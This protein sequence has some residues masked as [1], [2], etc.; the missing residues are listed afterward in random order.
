VTRSV[1]RPGLTT[2]QVAQR[3]AAGQANQVTLRTARSAWSIVRANVL[4]RFNA[5]IG[6]LL[7]VVLIFGA[8]Q[9]GLFGL[10]ILVN[11][12]VGIIQELRAKRT[13]DGLALLEQA[14]VRVRR[15]GAESEVAPE[16]VVIDDVILLATGAK[17]PVDGD[18]LTTE[19]LEVDESLLT[20]E[21]D[22]VA[23]QPGDPLLSGSFVVAGAGAFVATKVGQDAYA[24]RL[25]HDA[26]RFELAHS[27]LMAG[28][29]HI[30]R[31]I[32]WVIMPV[33]L[34][35]VVSQL[36][37]TQSLSEAMVS[38]VAGIVP[39]VPEG[40]VLLTSVAFAVGVIRLGRRNCL[41]QE[42]A[43]V[44]V[45]A[46]VDVLCLD[47]TG[48]LT[49]P[50]LDL[51]EIRLADQS[52]GEQARQALAA[53]AGLDPAPNATMRAIAASA[54]PA[55]DPATGWS[56]TATISFSSAR[57]YSA[58]QFGER[59]GWVL[60]AADIILA[61][62]DPQRAQAESLGATGL[63][64]LALGQLAD[65]RL[66]PDHPLGAVRPVALVVLRQ[67]LRPEAAE[68]LRFLTDEGLTVKIMSGDNA[69]SVGA[70][71]DTLHV[72]GAATPIDARVL[73]DEPTALAAQLESHTVFGR[74]T[75][76]Q[77]RTF[78]NA[79]R[80]GGHT[81]AMTGDGVNDALALKDADLG[82]A[83]GSGSPASRAVAKVVL[84]D[85]S[86][87]ALPRVL[88][89]GRRVLANIE[90]VASLFLVKTTYSLVLAVLVGIAHIPFPFLPRHVTLVGSLTIGIP[91]F[92]LA[93]AA[94]NERARPGFVARVLRFAAPAGLVCGLAAFLAYG[95]ARLNTSSDQTA[96]RSTATLTLFLA[97][98]WVLAT[99]ARPY[100]WWRA[101]LVLSMLA[102]FAFI[103]AVP[104]AAH[105]FA[106]DLT[107]I[108]NDAIALGAA[109]AAAVAITVI[110]RLQPAATTG[111]TRL[112]R[113]I[114]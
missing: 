33:G 42:L 44:E 62:D 50:Q 9:D 11:S 6:V 84:L 103:A 28:I 23:K 45:L 26:R 30:L 105:T 64:V 41:V 66:H 34:L 88:G 93:L 90:R 2:A 99:A 106:L 114:R 92:F 68:T 89:E 55:A 16:E 71:A 67:R 85:D 80:A 27:E 7:V 56:A 86:F 24:N 95:L 4:T 5:I 102:G 113:R 104:F 10:V 91:G 20:G 35:L 58:A 109:A 101:T 63:R 110:H 46:R 14:Q 77:K 94:N 111:W 72:P 32:T 59:G 83:M 15:D 21:A 49:A 8:P 52:T 79:L 57:K 36:R 97:A 100:T 43:A 65:G 37:G 74:V 54:D 38:S 31:V 17:V 19:G 73:P 29:N 47:K 108:T 87:A 12:A 13:L 61:A 98:T 81:V 60:G 25:V 107:D 75:P 1:I 70:V 82:I 40:L 18:L 3:R 76:E 78:V 112:R 96:D 39:M 22:P 53:L 51:V 69:A 48:T